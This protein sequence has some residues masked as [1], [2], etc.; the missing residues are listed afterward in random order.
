MKNALSVDVED[1]FHVSG[2]EHVVDRDRW[3]EYPVRFHIGMAKILAILD[4]HDIQATFFFLGWIAERYPEVVA[5]V[6]AR[7]HEVAV[8]GY[9]HHLVHRQRPDEFA[10]DLERA[11]AAVRKAYAGPILGYR[12]P[13]FSIRADT[14]WAL[15]IIK[16]LG[17]R[18]DSS[19]LPRGRGAY[20]FA[21]VRDMPYEILDGLLEFPVSTVDVLGR[22][23]PVGGGG[24]LR[25]YPFALT[26]R[27]IEWLNRRRG[28]PAI[29]Y[30][31]PWELDPEQPRIRAGWRNT[32]RHRVN[33]ERTERRLEELCTRFE[34]APVRRVL[35]V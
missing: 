31:H 6:G 14:P 32:F 4:R 27:A 22:K 24:Y 3:P 28:L 13:T 15:E 2:F 19:I 12:A 10:R 21:G 20:D 23:L 1:Y 25:F 5:D 8:H 26:C 29:V 34:L 33:L 18:Y 30:L 16:D 9:A 35:G 11:L 7:G 17:F